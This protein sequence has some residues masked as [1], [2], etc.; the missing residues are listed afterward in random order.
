VKENKADMYGMMVSAFL[1]IVKSL[2][3][4]TRKSFPPT[5]LAAMGPPLKDKDVDEVTQLSSSSQQ[6]SSPR[7]ESTARYGKEVPKDDIEAMTDLA[8]AASE[9]VQKKLPSHPTQK[10]HPNT[11]KIRA[12]REYSD[13]DSGEP[14]S[15]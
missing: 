8:I 7:Q 4:V 9:Q 14:K 10:Y 12:P 13:S 1:H 3:S 11:G 2:A 6:E 15:K 5:V